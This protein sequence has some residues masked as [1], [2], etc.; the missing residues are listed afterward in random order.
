MTKFIKKNIICRYRLPHHIITD[1]NVQFREKMATLL[2]EYKI[3]HHKSSPYR[4]QANGVVEAAN[5]NMKRILAK[6]LENY[7]DW[8]S[9]LHFS[10]WGYRTTTRISTGATTYSLVYGCEA[11]L[12]M[13]VKIQLLRVLLESNIL[14][15]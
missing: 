7:K 10:L 8:A 3:K 13:E 4:P 2:K 6:M 9:Y 14:E 15:Y 1:N 11:V 12:P 5:K